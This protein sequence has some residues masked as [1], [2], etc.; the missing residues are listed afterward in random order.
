MTELRR[1]VEFCERQQSPVKIDLLPARL[2]PDGQ[3]YIRVLEARSFRAPFYAYEIVFLPEPTASD[4]EYP[5]LASPVIKQLGRDTQKAAQKL[6]VEW[7]AY[8]ESRLWC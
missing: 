3:Q 8:H 7:M 4:Y 2:L 1:F 5:V 6:R